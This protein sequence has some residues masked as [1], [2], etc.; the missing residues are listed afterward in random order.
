MD[1]VTVM[2]G[3]VK[4]KSIGINTVLYYYCAVLNCTLGL[5]T[6]L[7]AERLLRKYTASHDK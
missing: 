3:L 5:V 6:A 4:T 7:H 2:L 1:A